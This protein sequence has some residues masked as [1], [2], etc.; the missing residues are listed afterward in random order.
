VSLLLILCAGGV[1]YL[2]FPPDGLPIPLSDVFR[3]RIEAVIA[4]NMPSGEVSIG[5]IGLSLSRGRLMPRIRFSDMRLSEGGGDRVVLPIL[6]V[7]LD[8]ASLLQGEIRPRQVALRGA[9]L[10]IRRNADGRLDLDVTGAET[11]APR[12]LAE[13]LAGIDRMFADPVFSALERVSGDGLTVLIEESRSGE[14]L[15]IDSAELS[16]IPQG[17]SLTLSVGGQLTGRAESALDLTFTRFAEL[18]QTAFN[19]RFENLHSRDVAVASDALAWL[20]LVDAP[21]SGQLRTVLFDDGRFGTLSGTLDVA[22]GQIVPGGGV[23]PLP[24]T[25]MSLA[26]DYDATTARMWIEQFLVEAPSLSARISGHATLLDGPVYL[27]QLEIDDI[28]A[29]P[30]GM[31]AAPLRFAGGALDFRLQLE[32][33]VAVDFGQAVLF[34]DGLHLSARGR[35]A[36]EEAGLSVRLDTEVPSLDGTRVPAFWPVD[37]LPNT[38]AWI[39]ERVVAGAITS[40][41]SGLRLTPGEAPQVALTFD[42]DGAE[43]HA[44]RG[45]APVEGGRGYLDISHDRVSIVLHEGHV[46]EPDGGR[47]DLAG[48]VMRIHDTRRRHSPATLDLDIAGAIPSALTLIA[49]EPFTLLD[50]FGQNPATVARGEARIAAT[51]DMVMQPRIRPADLTFGVDAQLRDVVSEELVPG[52]VLRAAA[53]RLRADNARLS[54]GG[55]ARLDGMRLDATWS[56]ALG[57]G[58]PLASTVEGQAVLTPQALAGF[59]LRLPED[60]LGGRGAAAFTLA[61]A[62]DTPPRLSLQSDLAGLSLSLP[63]LGWSLPAAETGRLAAEIT[64]GPEPQVT[65]LDIAG[66]GLSLTGSVALDGPGAFDRLRIERLRLG[67]WLDVT[68]ALI[69]QGRD[70]RLTITGGRA[71]MRGMPTGGADGSGDPLPLSLRLDRFEITDTIFLTDLTAELSGRPVGGSFRGRVGGEVPVTGTLSGEADGTALRLRS[72]DGGAVLRAAGI[73]PNS[74]GGA[75]D[76]ILRPLPGQGRYSGLMTIDNPRLRDAPA[77]AE[78][79]N[80]VSVVGLLDQLASGEGVALGEVRAAFSLSPGQVAIQEGTAIGPAMGLSLDG[81]YDIARRFL[82]FEGVVSPFYIVN[83]MMGGLFGTRHEGLFG[84]TYRLTGTPENSAVSVNPLSVFTP[85]IFREIFRRPPPELAQ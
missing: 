27:T 80:A 60:M 2:A 18:G 11:G 76:L 30:P 72:E 36:A 38:R 21:L 54:I 68:G 77:F 59:G 1:L 49:A 84:F 14:T 19:A 44:I 22:E 23:V 46:I 51:V 8:R 31:F 28:T 29:D 70:A 66:A 53:L 47:L 35:V 25:S 12:D 40:L 78:L 63:A 17:D 62:P 48:S 5:E 73:Y 74:Y 24:L 37:L 81:T 13:T 20:T 57:P 42:F 43:V 61:L 67:D 56:R 75:L 45:M 55:P 16:L 26:F 41:H 10:R 33:V 32:P 65:Q 79:L 71:D 4:D 15:R 69:G 83:G 50:R 6:D 9:G 3:A 52:R 64:L 34:D 39:E 58:S 7:E 82:D 85:G